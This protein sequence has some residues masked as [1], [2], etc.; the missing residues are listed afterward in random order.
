MQ[1]EL[2][3]QPL[4][5]IITTKQRKQYVTKQQ[6]LD[7]IIWLINKFGYNA[8]NYYK[9]SS[10]RLAEEYYKE[11]H[12]QLTKISI[13]RWIAGTNKQKYLDEAL[14][15]ML[16]NFVDNSLLTSL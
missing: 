10:Q 3:E 1:E 13:Y 5:Q 7:F 16:K 15:L 14:E 8:I 2:T 12:V 6:R 11:T 9:L 4:E